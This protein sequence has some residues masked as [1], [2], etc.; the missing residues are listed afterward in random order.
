MPALDALSSLASERSRAVRSFT[1]EPPI[2][3]AASPPFEAAS[4]QREQTASG[5]TSMSEDVF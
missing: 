1:I 4:W 5:P 3:A 2:W